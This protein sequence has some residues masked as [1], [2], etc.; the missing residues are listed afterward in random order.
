MEVCLP[1]LYPAVAWRQRFSVSYKDVKGLDKKREVA[2]GAVPVPRG[3]RTPH[4]GFRRLQKV[5][6]RGLL[7]EG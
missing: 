7:K 2:N 6:L 4:A 3:Q 5:I 1:R